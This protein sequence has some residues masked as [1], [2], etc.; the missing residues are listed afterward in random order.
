VW[1]TLPASAAY[2]AASLGL[3]QAGGTAI[4]SFVPPG[5]LS[6]GISLGFLGAAVWR[7]ATPMLATGGGA[8]L[9]GALAVAA[10]GNLAARVYEA[11]DGR[12]PATWVGAVLCAAGTAVALAAGWRM[13]SGSWRAAEAALVFGGL[14]LDAL[15]LG[16][17][18]GTAAAVLLLAAGL[19][20]LPPA[21]VALRSGSGTA[22]TVAVVTLA[23]V[24]GAATY[25]PVQVL[26]QAGA[27]AGAGF[28]FLSLAGVTGVLLAAYGALRDERVEFARVAGWVTAGGLAV[29]A[30]AAALPSAVIDGLAVPAAATVVRFPVESLA[31]SGPAELSLA[32]GWPSGAAAIV[33][34]VVVTATLAL[35][36]TRAGAERRALP[37]VTASAAGDWSQWVRTAI[38][39]VAARAGNRWPGALRPWGSRTLLAACA[40][41]AVVVL[42][43]RT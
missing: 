5:V 21:V 28:A 16:T 34:L 35:R 9:Q 12:L 36:R 13:A 22:R 6:V 19:L 7:V 15:G 27:E 14:A 10:G 38:G 23:I 4:F 42:I 30:A 24:P 33:L 11:G 29:G 17:P 25:L 18:A 43:V 39:P 3:L 1:L 37:A 40:T 32:G 2:L 31:A 26:V 8:L 20:L 41:G